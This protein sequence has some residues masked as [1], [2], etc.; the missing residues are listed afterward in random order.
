MVN[1]RKI[2]WAGEL[3]FGDDSEVV[4]ILNHHTG[5]VS[6]ISD[7]GSVSFSV[8]SFRRVLAVYLP[9]LDVLAETNDN[10]NHLF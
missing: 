2:N 4:S 6:T 7:C 5:P 1:G 10:L 8:L 9:F 3:V